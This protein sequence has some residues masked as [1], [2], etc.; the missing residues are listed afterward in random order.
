MLHG[1]LA[2]I[3]VIFLIVGIAASANGFPA[4]CS[5]LA[6][7]A[8]V[9]LGLAA[10]VNLVAYPETLLHRVSQCDPL[11][12]VSRGRSRLAFETGDELEQQFVEFFPVLYLGNVSHF[13]HDLQS[14]A[15]CDGGEL[16]PL[17]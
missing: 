15:G 2:A 3:G 16:L 14:R 5:S 9:P 10:C 4:G 7:P 8:L 17:R 12:L 6:V 11:T 1:L 13:L